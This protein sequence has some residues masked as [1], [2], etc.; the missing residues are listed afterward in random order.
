M[1][2]YYIDCINLYDLLDIVPS[3]SSM[4]VSSVIFPEK[5]FDNLSLKNGNSSEA[6]PRLS[7]TI[8]PSV[9]VKLALANIFLTL[10]LIN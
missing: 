6:T 8:F 1:N 4:M 5:L 9:S 10:A 3:V 2:E 7:K